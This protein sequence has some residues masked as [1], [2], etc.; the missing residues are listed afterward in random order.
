MNNIRLNAAQACES[1]LQGWSAGDSPKPKAGRVTIRSQVKNS[2][3][4]EDCH[5]QQ[6]AAHGHH[7]Y[8]PTAF[9]PSR[10]LHYFCHDTTLCN[11]L[12]SLPR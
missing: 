3:N 2:F 1:S 12:R 8:A 11:R 6:R 4:P 9:D 7:D 10:V 5:L